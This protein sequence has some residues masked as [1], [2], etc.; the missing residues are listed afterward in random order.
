MSRT[1][2]AAAGCLLFVGLA[3][4][5]DLP[6]LPFGDGRLASALRQAMKEHADATKNAEEDLIKAMKKETDRIN[7][8]PR[9]S[10]EDKIRYTDQIKEQQ[11]AFTE[12]GKLPEFRG[13]AQPVKDFKV[14]KQLA[15]SKC[16]RLF[17]AE[18]DR[19]N[20]V[21]VDTAKEILK[22]KRTY[23]NLEPKDMRT[24]WRTEER[25]GNYFV[26]VRTGYWLEYHRDGRPF[27]RWVE[28]AR[29]REHIDLKDTERNYSSRLLSD[30]WLLQTDPNGQLGQ[31]AR[32]K[33]VEGSDKK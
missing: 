4:A 3:S 12:G 18:A 29:T 13:L 10:V 24:H 5:A 25:E 2:L 28:V 6:D 8:H 21:N 33:W 1:S 23:L 16:E 15:D 31:F 14:R 32:G 20:K 9:Y 11:A 26:Q 17:N 7:S 30:R 22:L 27:A 19:Y